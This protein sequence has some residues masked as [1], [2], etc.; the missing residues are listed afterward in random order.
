MQV[1]F[2]FSDDRLIVVFVPDI[3]EPEQINARSE[4]IVF[5]KSLSLGMAH[6]FGYD[7]DESDA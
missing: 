3:K 1:Q 2:T 4:R 6:P 5:R 7:E